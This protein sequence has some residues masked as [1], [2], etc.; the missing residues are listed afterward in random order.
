MRVTAVSADMRRFAVGDAAYARP[1][2]FPIGSIA[3]RVSLHEDE[4]VRQPH[5]LFPSHICFTFD[6]GNSIFHE[7]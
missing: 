5:R 1:N 6:S 7:G 3:K 2:R 4:A